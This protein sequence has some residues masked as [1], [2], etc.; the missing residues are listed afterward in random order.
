M[1][2]YNAEMYILQKKKH[3]YPF[4]NTEGFTHVNH[5]QVHYNQYFNN[6]HI[7]Y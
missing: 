5:A 1:Q 6:N 4:E 2:I 3:K 7:K